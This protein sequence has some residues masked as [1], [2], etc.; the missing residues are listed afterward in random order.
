M[1]ENT[2]QAQVST[3]SEAVTTEAPKA[4][5][6]TV[7]VKTVEEKV[8]IRFKG[9]DIP[10]GK[11]VKACK[12]SKTKPIEHINMWIMKTFKG[13]DVLFVCI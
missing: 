13:Q 4:D 12:M 3:S 10:G 6:P 2:E 8:I 11:V 1:T 9:I 5:Q 7:A